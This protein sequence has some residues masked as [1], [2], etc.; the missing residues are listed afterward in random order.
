MKK[1]VKV[2]DAELKVLNIIWKEKSATSKRIVDLVQEIEEWN[3]KTVHTLLKR[4]VEKGAVNAIKEGNNYIYT[5]AIKKREFQKKESISFI[6][7]LYN[8][9]I[10][11][12][13]TSFI[14]DEDISNEEIEKLYKLLDSKKIDN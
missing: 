1:D 10:S 9:S 8:G 11:S 13:V 12:L 2:S 5:P 3:R 4:L 6:K 14:E 7:K